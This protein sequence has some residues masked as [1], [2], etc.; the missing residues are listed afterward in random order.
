MA[1]FYKII[2]APIRIE[3][4]CPHCCWD[5]AVDWKEVESYGGEYGKWTGDICSIQCENCGKEVEF[6][7]CEVD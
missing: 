2:Q 5:N 3:F 7:D 6:N 1:T 4:D